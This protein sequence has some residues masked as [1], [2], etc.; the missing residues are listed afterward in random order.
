MCCAGR[1]W[2][3]P[4]DAHEPASH[5][6]QR[7]WLDDAGSLYAVTPAGPGIVLDRDLP[8]LLDQLRAQDGAMPLDALAELTPG[9]PPLMVECAAYGR[10]PLRMATRADLPR[11]LGFE[12]AAPAAATA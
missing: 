10:A 9:Q 3:G 12:P 11:I 7:R 4:A 8:A 1:R 6:G 2:P 5:G